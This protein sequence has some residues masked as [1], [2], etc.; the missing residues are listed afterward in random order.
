MSKNKDPNSLINIQHDYI[1]NKIKSIQQPKEI[2]NL[3]IDKKVETIL[4]KTFTKEQ[5]LR[6]VA[7]VELIASERRKNTYMTAIYMVEQSIYN[8]KCIMADVTTKR[9]KR[10]MTLFAYQDEDVD[11]KGTKFFNNKFLANPA[12][13]DYLTYIGRINFEYNAVE[14]RVFLTDDKTANSMPI[15]YNKNVLN[16][17]MPQ[18]KQ[19]AKCLLNVM[20]SMEEYPFIRFYRPVDA[21]Y[22]AKRLPEL[23]ADEFQKQMDEYCR[24]NQNYP[25]PEVSAKTRSILLITDRTID[26]FAPLLHEFTYQ[27]MAMDIV[28]SLEREGVFKYQSENEK[29]EV[30]DVEATLNNEN[31]EDWVN[32]RHLHIIESSELIVNKITELVK[33]N[34]LMIDRSKASTSSDLMYIVAH[35]KG[36]DEERRQLTL[37]KTL[38]D[39]CLDIN[40][41]RKLAEFAAD[42]EQTCC[43]DGVSFE[44]ERNKHLHDDLIVLL[45]RDDL[46]INDKMRLIL[47]YAYYRGGLIRADFEKLIKFIG[48]DDRHIT[49]LME[50]CFNNV[51]KLGFQL[52]KTDIKDKPFGKQ[53]FHTINNEGT[54]NTSRYTPGVK[55]I[56]QNVA[57]YS[58]DREWFPYFRDIPLDDE[59]V[60][61]E[62]KGSNAKKDLQSSGTLR[63]P[64]IKASWASQTGTSSSNLSR[65][66][67]G[68]GVGGHKQKQ[69]IFCYVAGGITY[70][71]IRSIYELSSSLNKEFYIGSES[72]LRP[73]DFLI[74]LQNLSENKT[75]EALDLNIVKESMKSEDIP[76][77]LYNDGSSSIPRPIPR[78]QMSGQVPIRG[79]GY[80]PQHQQHQQHQQQPHPQSQPQFGQVSSFQQQVEQQQQMYAKAHGINHESGSSSNGAGSTSGH[81]KKRSSKSGGGGGESSSGS[82]PAPPGGGSADG[83]GSSSSGK[84]SRL[85]KF[86]K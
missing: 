84:R 4:Y 79:A 28:Q 20:I 11:P 1:Y 46:H 37:H 85:K 47:I 67:G 60:V 32:L 41:S 23:I 3:V 38:I 29:G 45:A 36:F 30:N 83:S 16:F 31:D 18:I 86:F 26:L 72:I 52:F 78:Q 65:Y 27:A 48:V 64:R 75:L 14:T 63:N 10:G 13:V 54:Y 73:R 35:L 74:G 2:Y 49:G 69:R 17:V 21:N 19:V 70:N 5:L 55:T 25:T 57:K 15:Y 42:F 56:M 40:A 44:G 12:V 33:N 43:A 59:V 71:E 6:I 76:D 24:S 8:L 58:L 77:F 68:G 34:P 50:R 7:S 39:K 80:P 9:Y 81:Y 51:D 66:G 62:P 82:S 53:Y 22:D 61:T